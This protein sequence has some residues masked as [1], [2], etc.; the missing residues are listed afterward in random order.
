MLQEETRVRVARPDLI[1]LDNLIYQ[2]TDKMG[3]QQQMDPI[4]RAESIKL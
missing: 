2:E 4:K 1:L 3:K